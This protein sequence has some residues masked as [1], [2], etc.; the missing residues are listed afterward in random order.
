MKIRRNETLPVLL[1][2]IIV[3]GASSQ[4]L[5]WMRA[6]DHAW[7]R[8]LVNDSQGNVITLGR[9]AGAGVLLLKYTPCGEV[10]WER[11]L[12]FYDGSGITVDPQD[13]IIISA[14]DY[15][16]KMNSVGDSLWG[17][18]LESYL[19]ETSDVACD[20]DGNVFVVGD[21]PSIF[22]VKLSPD[23]EILWTQEGGGSGAYACAVD[24][25]GDVIVAG[26]ILGADWD[27][28]I[29]KYSSEGEI[30]WERI[31]GGPL[32]DIP[33][34][35]CVDSDDNIYVAAPWVVKYDPDG[36]IIWFDPPG[37]I[38]SGWLS[39]GGEANIYMTRNWE[40]PEIICADLDG[41]VVWSMQ[42]LTGCNGSAWSPEC[43][44]TGYLAVLQSRGVD[45]SEMLTTR[46]YIGSQSGVSEP[47]PLPTIVEVY[48][49][50]AKDFATFRHKDLGN[51]PGMV[52]VYDLAGRLIRSLEASDGMVFWDCRDK[53]GKRVSPGTYMCG[54]V[55][56]NTFRGKT[57]VVVTR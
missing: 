24:S 23:G 57:Y 20:M 48:P 43:H 37:L 40:Y 27:W 17:R 5:I 10:A 9:R 13:N 30:L 16:V 44:G 4:E 26:K 8:K 28:K 42:G 31:E 22:T 47:I 49:N 21:E 34:S 18:N 50:P 11:Q 3:G 38:G 46:Y 14:D 53:E 33:N 7:G 6:E 45:V 12:S 19:W 39:Y 41:N 35:V 51:V 25:R 55:S 1:M 2:A 56:R 29:I 15:V 32:W 36:N 52:A 54:L